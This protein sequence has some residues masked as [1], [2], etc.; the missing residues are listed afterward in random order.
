MEFE[1]EWAHPSLLIC[2]VSGRSTVEGCVALMQAATSESQYRPDIGVLTDARNIDV[3]TL[4]ATDIEFIAD[5]SAKF[6]AVASVRS[7]VVVG[8]D[9]P[10]R[11]GLARM[12]EAYADMRKIGL[13]RVFE[14]FDEAMA[15]LTEEDAET[16]SE[17]SSDGELATT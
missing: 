13:I 12:F 9:S 14:T 8:P 16:L 3:S 5:L 15:W 11:Y 2:R 17:A 10:V 7:A 4:T 1:L 6:A